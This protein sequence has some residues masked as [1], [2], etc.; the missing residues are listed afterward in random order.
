M[1]SKITY[2]NIRVK[3]AKSHITEAAKKAEV[4]MPTRVV[5][6]YADDATAGLQLR[7]QGQRAFWVLKYRNSTKTLGYVYA[8][9]EPH[10]M[11]PSVS[12]ARSLAAEGKKVIDDDPKKFDSFLSTYYAIQERD[13]EQARKEA[14]GQITTW[15]L[16]QCIEHVIEARTATGEKKPLKNPY[17][18]QLTLR[19]PELQNLL[20]QPAAALDRGDFDDAR[21]ILK[22]N[23]GK[24]PANK[25]LSNIRRSLDYCMRFQSKASGLSHHDQWW[26][27]IESAGVV[28]KRTRLPKI[29]DIVQMMI[30]MEDFLDKPLPGRK[31]RDGKAGVRANVF[32]AAWWL[33]LTGQRTFAAL[34][35]HR[36]DFFP[37]KEAGNG[38][39]I[40]AW[41]AS[42]M[43]ATVDFSLPVP[44]RVVQHMLPLIEASRNDVNDGSTWAFPSGRKPKKSSAKKDI[45]V[46]QSAVRLALQR[47][48]GRDPLMKGN[49]EAVDFF[50]RCK[51]PWWTPHDIRKC[52]TAFMD[53]S[54]MPGGASAILAHKIK[55][56]DLPH[57]DKDREDWLEQHVEDVTAA[58]YFSPG[59]MHLKAKAMSL[60]TDAILDR[61]EALSPRAQ[62]KIQ[63][64]KRIQRAKFIFQDALYAHRARD[65]ALIAI[66]PLIEAQRVKVSKTERM[67][68]TMMTETPVPLKDIA[69]A[70]DELQGY[71]D[72]LDRLVTAPGTALIKPSEEARK[73]SMVDVMHHGFSTYDFRSE[74]PDYCELRDR[75]ITGLISI[76][77][78]KSTLSDKC[79][80]DFSLDTQSMYLPGRE[81]V[82]AIAS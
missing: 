51:I 12:E 56:P 2:N 77:T 80:Y 13:P 71:Q 65:A 27:L 31:S 16:R 37:D 53:K 44:P 1:T 17:E 14:R 36:H 30:V 59:H 66:Q 41:P 33:V 9:Q 21:D 68:E 82:S 63:E 73:G 47:L 34:H 79:G 23:Y 7:V 67:I 35:L 48:R 70:K 49:A 26:K 32:A 75:Y 8:E 72:D 38:W 3:I 61:Y 69:F 18:Y 42:V 76:E 57:N 40:A 55:M 60:W 19:R 64:E 62:A 45:T 6:I 54:G 81:P 43:K 50:A 20:D 28:E 58:S 5:D 52:L 24:S 39:Y 29:D 78:F 22:K 11:I 25:A 10:Q 46:N 15:T 4:G 74:A